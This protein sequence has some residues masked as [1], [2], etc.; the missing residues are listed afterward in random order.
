MLAGRLS[1]EAGDDAGAREKYAWEILNTTGEQSYDKDKKLFILDFARRIFRLRDPRINPKVKEAYAMQTIPLREYS[2][3]VKLDNAREDG[4]EDGIE[5]G[6]AK[7]R[8][9]GRVEG[10]KKVARSMIAEG[11]SAEAIRRCTG[12]EEKEIV[13]IQ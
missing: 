11:F 7:G 12:L 10:I 8:V 6:I 3:Q 9:E 4:R 2:Q 5:E 1:L 13:A